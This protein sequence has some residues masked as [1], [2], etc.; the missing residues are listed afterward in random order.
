MNRKLTRNEWIA[1]VV[2]LIAVGFMLFI[3]FRTAPLFS[4][5]E[6]DS[7][8]S[9]APES[10]TAEK[11]L[12]SEI[13]K[14][15]ESPDTLKDF[16]N[17]EELGIIDAEIGTGKEAKSGDTVVVHYTGFLT[18]GTKFDS[19][20]NNGQP[21]EFVLGEGMLI[22]GWEEGVPGMKEGGLRIL[23]VP[24]QLGYGESEVGPIPPNSVLVFLVNLVEV[25]N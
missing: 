10:D 6:E 21:V 4:T 15:L 22:A 14:G 9:F 19:S 18:D 13:E 8:R 17:T 25:K 1:I 7:L 20:F 11:A 23:V 24:P 3:S 5:I 16:E 2:S 12:F